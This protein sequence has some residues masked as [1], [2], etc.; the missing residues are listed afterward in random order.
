MEGNRFMENVI[1]NILRSVI[2]SAY[3][4]TRRDK[5]CR[6]FIPGDSRMFDKFDKV[7]KTHMDAEEESF[8]NRFDENMMA[9]LNSAWFHRYLQYQTSVQDIYDW[10]IR[11]KKDKAGESKLLI[12]TVRRAEEYAAACGEGAQVRDGALLVSDKNVLTVEEKEIIRKFYQMVFKVIRSTIEDITPKAEA[13]MITGSQEE[14]RAQVIH[15]L[16]KE[17]LSNEEMLWH[18]RYCIDHEIRECGDIM[19]RL[20]KNGRWKS[21]VRQAAAEYNC[22]FMGVEEVCEKLLPGLCG[23]LYYWTVAQFADTGDERLKMQLK[24]HAEYYTGQEMLQD[25]CLVKM[26]DKT[27]T[28]RICRYLE[29]MRHVPR[30]VEKPDLVLAIG[31]IRSIE[32][33]EELERL[34]VL[35][36]QDDFRDRSCNGLQAALTEALSAIACIGGQEYEQVV[37]LLDEKL[38]Y[39]HNQYANRLAAIEKRQQGI[40]Y[41]MEKRRE[42]MKSVCKAAEKLVVLVHLNE[43]IRWRCLHMQQ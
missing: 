19:I 11:N 5:V 27:G 24:R 30:T 33:L 25:I 20:A 12:M 17:K 6:I 16:R 38:K 32:L 37:H 36:M 13:A 15:N 10:I 31:E 2:Y 41:T 22:R 39:Y 26:Q 29:R 1:T 8:Q 34:L 18:I 4:D 9:V 14:I 21:W 40:A 3:Q 35:M 23:K 7:L 42:D 43:D 28:R